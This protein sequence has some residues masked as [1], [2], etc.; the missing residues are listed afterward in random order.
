MD[1][2]DRMPYGIYFPSANRS[3][4]IRQSGET[5]MPTVHDI[6]CPACETTSSVIKEGLNAY[7]CTS[8]DRQFSLNDVV[9]R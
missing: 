6:P 5:D 4:T 7:R 8:C 1:S 2:I 3:N 9:D